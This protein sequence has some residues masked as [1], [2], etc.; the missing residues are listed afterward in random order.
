MKQREVQAE[1]G[2]RWTCVQA[3]AGLNH[4]EENEEAATVGANDDKRTVVCTPSG[5]A[6]TVR[7]EL[8]ANWEEA[9]SDEELLQEIEA[10]QG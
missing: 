9:Y 8:P 3:Y 1:D 4:T 10:N 7:L 6:Q 2:T 5:G